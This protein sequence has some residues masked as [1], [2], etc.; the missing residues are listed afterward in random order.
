[1]TQLIS[2]HLSSFKNDEMT[3]LNKRSP[4]TA[5]TGED[6]SACTLC[7]RCSNNSVLRV[8]QG[9]S[10]HSHQH[11][12]HGSTECLVHELA[13][14]HRLKEE[15]DEVLMHLEC[16]WDL[17]AQTVKRVGPVRRAGR[18]AVGGVRSART[19]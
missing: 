7:E 16:I 6:A 12:D 1:M 10:L 19:L 18:R 17:S 13:Q 4:S 2:L 3:I 14:C 5:G 8:L 11:H 15:V 9:A